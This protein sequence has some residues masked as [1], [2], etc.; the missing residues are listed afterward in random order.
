LDRH[1]RRRVPRD[2]TSPHTNDRTE[3]DADGEAIGQLLPFAVG[4]AISPMPIV[5]MVLML[6]TPKAK[7]NG[8]AFIA[9]WIVGVALAGAVALAIL[10]PTSTSDDG[11]TASWTYWLKILLGL[12]LVALAAK[13]WKAR[14]APDAEV[15]MPKWM[16]MLDGFIAPKAAGLAVLLSALNPKNL[17]FIIG[18]A[19]A[20]SQFDLG[21]AEQAAAWAVFTVIAAVGVAVPMAIYLFMGTRAATTLGSLKDWMARNNT[22]VMAVLLLVIGVKLVGDAITGLAA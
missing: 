8:F 4:V 7:S 18:G 2:R 17:V 11:A 19:A 12:L 9:G 22:A 21:V 5:A 3:G 1:Q 14:P 20:V 13:E 10:G 15:P 6:I 16:G